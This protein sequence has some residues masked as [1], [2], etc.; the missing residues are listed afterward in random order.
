M[1]QQELRKYYY[2]FLRWLW[3]IALGAL[4]CGGAAYVVGE[5]TTPVYSATTTLLIHQAPAVGTSDYTALLT[6]ERL[7]QTYSEMLTGRPVLDTVIADLGLGET[8]SGLAKRVDVSVVQNT[9]LIRLSVEDTNP[10]LAA[11]IANAV[12]G[13]FTDQM[14]ELQ[15]SRYAGSL[16]GIQEEMV[17]V[18][19]LLDDVQ[20]NVDELGMPSN[21]DELADL[22][23]LQSIQA[24]Y[25]NTYSQLVQNY[26][27]MKM[28]A[29]L[30]A[31]DL[32]VYEPAQPPAAPVRPQV[33]RNTLLAVVVG[34][35]LAAGVVFLI[36]YLDDKIRTPDD[37]RQALGL[38]SLGLI[39]RAEGEEKEL[40]VAWNTR[41]LVAEAFR[42]LR[43]NLR[44][45][46]LDKP[47]HT[48]LI[49]SP[50]VTEGKSFTAA[51]LAVCMAETNVKAVLVD[52][53][54]R[55]PRQHKIF[56]TCS[57]GSKG[58]TG[59]L[60]DGKLDGNIST[61]GYG[62]RLMVLPA[63]ELPPNPAELLGSQR[64]AGVLDEL[65]GLADVVL[66]DT[67]PVLPVADAATLASMVDGVLLVVQA[68][69]TT[70]GA[71]Q[72][73]LEALRKVGANVIGVV[74]NGVPFGRGRYAGSYYYHYYYYYY[75][76]SYYG[77][78]DGKKRRRGKH[79]RVPRSSAG[80]LLEKKLGAG[81]KNE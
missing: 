39:G 69:N 65:K 8:S 64:M 41:S 11:A 15:E 43:T 12:A 25:R 16:A 70:V 73:A 37:V 36:D 18:S 77:E 76:S 52:A 5:R 66:I 56:P 57:E 31:D 2:L 67:T 61:V 24:G 47:L 50:T 44:F 17:N 63:G 72:L 10:T 3:L 49:T 60:L 6:S 81:N 53:D 62:G 80:Q 27:Q 42:A 29:A 23:R 46:G 75:H 20:A 71:A 35:M 59:T 48:I 9:Q 33:L 21:A 1:E 38:E 68:G 74:L 40:V 79:R 34:A 19:A 30:S 13:A 7:A 55:R 28:T 78:G 22:T 26:E 58:L 54:L 32:I 4:L 14:R 51:N 45:A